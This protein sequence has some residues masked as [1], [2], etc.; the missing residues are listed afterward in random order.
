MIAARAAARSRERPN[1]RKTSR[2][3]KKEAGAKK[4]TEDRVRWGASTTLSGGR[5]KRIKG[6]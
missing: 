3:R 2:E 6:I 5:G 4:E 1:L